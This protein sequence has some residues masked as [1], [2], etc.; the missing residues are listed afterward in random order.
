M[1]IPVACSECG[2]QFHAPIE[3]G[4]KRAKC[5]GCGQIFVIPQHQSIPPK[6]KPRAEPVSIQTDVEEP[7]PLPRTPPPPLSHAVSPSPSERWY[8]R[9]PDGKTYGP[10]S[11]I[12]LRHW[13]AQARFDAT[14]QLI[15]E[16]SNH[17]ESAR[18]LFSTLPNDRESVSPQPSGPTAPTN[19][20]ERGGF[21]PPW[22]AN[23][24]RRSK[25]IAIVATVGTVCFVVL[26]VFLGSYLAIRA[27][28]LAE[29]RA[30]ELNRQAAERLEG[31]WR[32]LD[33]GAIEESFVFH[34]DGTVTHTFSNPYYLLGQGI[35]RKSN[36]T[37]Y[38][39]SVKPDEVA[40]K[41]GS[42]GDDILYLV[43]FESPYL[44]T[45]TKYYLKENFGGYTVS[46][47]R[48]FANSLMKP[49]NRASTQP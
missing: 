22:L 29:Q 43:K 48:K 7:P 46:Q 3:Y 19:S 49:A 24:P 8:L 23:I 14:S 34:P 5:P 36:D 9:T 10:V 25:N 21:L 16:G 40:L 20:E 42:E 30:A 13:A 44:A 28:K 39:T 4:G 37:W 35:D 38:A 33:A 17:W 12:E 18:R 31:T 1:E 15:R 41:L 26:I 47:T 27:Q 6:P 45:I 11:Q 2:K 32:L